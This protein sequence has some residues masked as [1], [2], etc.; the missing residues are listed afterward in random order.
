MG[1]TDIWSVSNKMKK[2]IIIMLL[3]IT[4]IGCDKTTQ[5]TNK[6]VTSTTTT[7]VVSATLLPT[8]LSTPENLKITS[9]S[10]LMWDSVEGA[11]KYIVTVNGEEHQVYQNFYNLAQLEDNRVYSITVRA[12][13]IVSQ[14]SETEA[15]EYSNFELADISLNVMYSVYLNDDLKVDI[16]NIS[17]VNEIKPSIEEEP[18]NSDNWTFSDGLL[19]IKKSYLDTI[20]HGTPYLL[21][22]TSNGIIEL[23][24]VFNDV[25]QPYL[26]Y[27]QTYIQTVNHDL[28]IRFEA[29]NGILS[30]LSGNDITEDDYSVTNSVLT[31][32]SQFLDPL[33][34]ANPT[35][36]VII[37]YNFTVGEDTVIGIIVI[38][39]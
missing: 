37:G 26:I 16:D 17:A 35:R 21:I 15:I 36:N 11:L 29:M 9:A 33:F 13:N 24:I 22:Y 6:S 10:I 28:N 7:T 23:N 14:S 27:G 34:N 2:I 19:S 20:N 31:I 32:S 4:L 39:R 1:R 5:T 8:Q 25:N 12:V 38:H 18:I 30:G 3:T